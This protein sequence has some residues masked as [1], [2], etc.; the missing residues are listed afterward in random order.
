MR[1]SLDYLTTVGVLGQG[2]FAW[3]DHKTVTCA[4]GSAAE[5]AVKVVLPPE[6]PAAAADASSAA[7]DARSA[8]SSEADA[9][10]SSAGD[11][12][13]AA[14]CSIAPATC[15]SD[16]DEEDGSDTDEDE[17]Q[18]S[19]IGEAEEAGS[20]SSGDE[21]DDSESD[22]DE[23]EDAEEVDVSEQAMQASVKARALRLGTQQALRPALHP[24]RPGLAGRGPHRAR[25]AAGQ[26]RQSEGISLV[27][28][29]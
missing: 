27:R 29:S 3:V 22:E 26:V 12:A 19:D 21:E 20:E 10:A 14:A 18:D 24:G 16:K 17:D 7:A 13:P 6:Q 11:P 23:E 25:P 28:T 15:G 1:V 8:A 9:A 5:V 4:D 2:G